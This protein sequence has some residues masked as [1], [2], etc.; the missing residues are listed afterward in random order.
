MIVRDAAEFITETLQS[1]LPYIDEW[2][3]V[4]TG[5][6]DNTKQV[7]QNFFD[8]AR[9]EGQLVERP[10]IGF[11][12]NR[13]EAIAL[14]T[15]RADYAFMIDADDLVEGRLDLSHLDAAGYCVRFGPHNVYWR[16]ALFSLNKNWEFRGAVHEYAVCLEGDPTINLNGDYNF[17]FRSLGNRGK[18]PLKFQRDIDVLLA[19]YE[20]DPNDPRTVFY[21]AQSY[22]DHG[23][24]EKAIEWY[25]HRSDMRGWDEETFVATLELGKLLAQTKIDPSTVT[26]TFERAWQLRPSR[27]EALVEL[28]RFHRINKHWLDGY[29]VAYRASSIPFPEEDRL[30]VDASAYR[31]RALD[32]LAICA[33]QLGNHQEAMSACHRLLT[34]PHLPFD[35]R[36]RV[37]WNQTYSMKCLGFPQNIIRDH[38]EAVRS[39]PTADLTFTI[40][41]CRRRELFERTMDSFLENCLDHHLISRWICVDDA[42]SHE[43]RQLM[44]ERYPF[45]EFIYKDSDE[46]G[47]AKS[48]NRLLAEVTTKHWLHFE[49][50]WQTVKPGNYISHAMAVLDDNDSLIQCVLNRNYAE[51]LDNYNIVGGHL[52]VSQDQKTVYRVHDFI[53]PASP[54][55]KSLLEENP[56]RLTNAYWPG[57]S[58]MPSLLRR[59]AFDSLGSFNPGA[60][61]FERDMADR[62]LKKRWLTACIDDLTMLNIGR[63]RIETNPDGPLNAYQLL[64]VDQFT[65]YEDIT[66]GVITNWTDGDNVV[67]QWQRQFP[68]NGAWKGVRLVTSDVD[69]APHFTL[70]INHPRNE[71]LPIKAETSIVVHMEP[72]EGT[73]QYG[74]WAQPDS[75]HFVHVHSR[76]FATNFLEWHLD[77]SYDHLATTSPTKSADLS[78]IVTGKRLSLGHHFRLDLIHHLESIGQAID[79]FGL[80]NN[81]SFRSYRGELPWLD[82]REGLAP[83]RYTIAVENNSE[84]NYVTEKLTDAI[85]S[86]CLPFYWGCPNLEDIIEPD[87]FIRLP[88]DD[89]TVATSIIREAIANDEYS[90]RLPAIKRSKEK[91]LN[92]LQ[93]APTVSRLV[94]GHKLLDRTPIH[95]IN[96]DRRP[97]RLDGFMQRVSL[98]SGDR[99]ASRIARFSA[100][101]GQDLEMTPEI[102]HMFRGSDLPLRRSQTACALSHLS[103]WI[104]LI[105]SEH[106]HYIIFEDDVHFTS[107]FTSRIGELLGQMIDR[108]QTDV[109]F[110]GLAYFE[111]ALNPQS[112]IQTTRGVVLENLMGGTFG[113][114]ISKSGAKQL[115]EIAQTEGIAYGIDTFILNNS[116][117]LRLFE[118]VPNI[119]ATQVARR[120]GLNVDSDIQ[121]EDC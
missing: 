49:D 14:C 93:I 43:D 68:N 94:R 37:L 98:A 63:L 118:A 2:V 21:L 97:D 101:D 72:Y 74:D 54:E 104:E 119:V 17:V 42:S 8:E 77:I 76:D 109:I 12:H 86:E 10:W 38:P 6:V 88:S 113:Y 116:N 53:N 102:M 83:Y 36:E 29:L 79:I 27:A 65:N 28:A 47:H 84:N 13:T 31:W 20:K 11:A 26:E 110:L 108:P 1:V 19:E 55:F 71:D 61:H 25:R 114:I 40:T 5:S 18:D 60:G 34:S 75:T 64:G 56:G 22:R 85:L 48:M 16:P 3:I 81:E 9:L 73:S 51:I 95:V 91:L 52:V 50:D 62:A 121:Y 33:S 92:S 57:F 66:V 23:D 89:I 4:D 41:T 78:A 99:L 115:F 100:I 58:L 111:D 45:F 67:R 96:L 15:G 117:R 39:G 44:R 90:R 112:S 7:I 120:G 103:L 30:F 82:K 32:E 69:T 35:Q 24:T 105:N 70:V 59:S 106:D 46:V 87:S 107:D 80:D